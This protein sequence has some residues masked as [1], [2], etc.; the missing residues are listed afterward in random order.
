VKS[1]F[2]FLDGRPE[3]AARQQ[4]LAGKAV[5]QHRQY[6]VADSGTKAVDGQHDAALLGEEGRQPLAVGRGEGAEFVV[7]VQQVAAGAECADNA[8]V[9]QFL[10]D[11]RNAAM[12]GVA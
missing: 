10:V 8:A 7:A 9:S 12:F 6:F 1:P 2:E 11:L 5:A 3:Q 4:N